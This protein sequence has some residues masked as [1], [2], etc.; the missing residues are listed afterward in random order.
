L[1][2]VAGMPSPAI[3][4]LSDYGHAGEFVGVCHAVIA[5]RAPSARVIDL[6]HSIPCYDVRAGEPLVRRA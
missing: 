5:R 2:E 3:A 1:V 4:F 6:S